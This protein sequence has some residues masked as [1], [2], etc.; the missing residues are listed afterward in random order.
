MSHGQRKRY[1]ITRF[2]RLGL[3][4]NRGWSDTVGYFSSAATPPPRR[5]ARTLTRNRRVVRLDL[6]RGFPCYDSPPLSLSL[7]LIR[8]C[9]VFKIRFVYMELA[10]AFHFWIGTT[11]KTEHRKIHPGLISQGYRKKCDNK[12]LLLSCG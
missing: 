2:G 12:M 5:A 4:T 6:T 11:Q 8:N 7:W 1:S 10:I 9:Q 3:L